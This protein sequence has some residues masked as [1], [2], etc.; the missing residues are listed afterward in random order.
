[1]ITM[2][3]T[4]QAAKQNRKIVFLFTHG[5]N[6]THWFCIGMD[7]VPGVCF[8]FFYRSC[9][10]LLLPLLHRTLAHA[11]ILWAHYSAE[12]SLTWT[13][14][15]LMPYHQEVVLVLLDAGLDCNAEAATQRECNHRC[16]HL[17]W[18]RLATD[19]DGAKWVGVHTYKFEVT[20]VQSAMQDRGSGLRS[21]ERWLFDTMWSASC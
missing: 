1:M 15:L 12:A 13:P 2:K 19:R 4:F 18:L 7:L 16:R 8:F 20:R 3:P 17:S 9:F 5:S 11:L 14:P 6:T 10:L 21:P